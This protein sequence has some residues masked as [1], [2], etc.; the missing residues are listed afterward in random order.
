MSSFDRPHHYRLTADHRTVPV[1]D[2]SEFARDFGDID[3]R[4]VAATQ[5]GPLWI[6][7]VFLGIDHNWSGGPPL[8][9]ETMV[10]GDAEES[11]EM[12]R[13]STWDEAVAGHARVVAQ[14]E[15]QLARANAALKICHPEG[16]EK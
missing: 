12:H 2:Y 5:V 11:G 9:F 13:Y 7:T 3:N 1:S 4:R 14:C 6:S 8:L 10:F 15:E 16:N